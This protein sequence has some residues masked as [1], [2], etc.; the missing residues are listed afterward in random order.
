MQFWVKIMVNML[1]EFKNFQVEE[2]EERLKIMWPSPHNWFLL[3]LFSLALSIWLVMLTVMAGYLI[4]DV[5]LAGERYSFLLSAMLLLWLL[6]W[7]QFGRFL[8]KRWQFYAAN[9]EILFIDEERLI[10]R[11]PVSVL[12][13]TNAYD[14]QHVSPFYVSDKRSSPVFDYGHQHIYFGDALT[15]DEA[16]GLV[17]EVNGRFFPDLDDDL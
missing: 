13:I 7:V 3:G 9:R 17:D 2:D 5:M 8:W 10:I 14:M 11:R 4:S 1:F 6:I 12:G 16:R 15:E